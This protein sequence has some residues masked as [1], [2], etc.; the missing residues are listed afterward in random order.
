MELL[1]L[2]SLIQQPAVDM[3][4]T[5]IRMVVLVALVAVLVERLEQE[6]R[7]TH[8]RPLHL[9][10]MPAVMELITLATAQAVVVAVLVQLVKAMQERL[11]PVELVRYQ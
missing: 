4:R 3:V 11:H 1:Q 2:H 8:L 5:T 10:D 9:K 7:V 6:A